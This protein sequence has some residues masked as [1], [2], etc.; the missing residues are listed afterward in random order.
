MSDLGQKS[1]N[2][3][4]LWYM[5]M[6]IS[7]YSFILLFIQ[8]FISYTS[9]VSELSTI[10]AFSHINAGETKKDLFVKSSKVNL[11]SSIQ[12]ISNAGVRLLDFC[13]SGLSV[14]AALLGGRLVSSW[15]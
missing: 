2:D 11:G 6:Y 10:Y 7:L 5:Y 3:I 15:C 4:D 1:N 8:T 12:G 9:I 13:R 14:L